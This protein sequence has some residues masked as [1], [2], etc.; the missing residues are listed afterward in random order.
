MLVYNGQKITDVP[1]I[2]A[3]IIEVWVNGCKVWPD[4]KRDPKLPDELIKRVRSCFALGEWYNYFP[5][6]NELE[7]SNDIIE[8]LN[9]L[10]ELYGTNYELQLDEE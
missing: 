5:W 7:W 9:Y 2:K 1:Q 8:A 10:N 6:T 4:P 3:R